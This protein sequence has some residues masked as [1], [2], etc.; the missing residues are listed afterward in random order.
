MQSARNLGEDLFSSQT[1]SPRIK[2]QLGSGN[3]VS[4]LECL[5]QSPGLNPIKILQLDLRSPCNLTELEQFFK[6]KKN[7]ENLLEAYPH[8]LQGAS[9]EY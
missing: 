9:T 7:V 8:R 4:V 2:P 1:M 6:E 3:S 5:S